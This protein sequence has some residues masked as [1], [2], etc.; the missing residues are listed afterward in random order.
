MAAPHPADRSR[1][2]GSHWPRRTRRHRDS[3]ALRN[4][5]RRRQLHP[6][7]HQVVLLRQASHRARTRTRHPPTDCRS[8]GRR[9]I[10][11]AFL[12]RRTELLYLRRPE[13]DCLMDQIHSRQLTSTLTW[14]FG[15]FVLKKEKGPARGPFSLK[16]DFP[17]WL[18]R[19]CVASRVAQADQTHQPKTQQAD[20]ARLRHARS[21]IVRNDCAFADRVSA[22]VLVADVSDA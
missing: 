8:P 16:S 21:V 9:Y 22:V 17:C 7:S 20:R 10:R 19:Y 12:H 18:G 4:A 15:A 14:R 1:S 5:L 3:Y 6:R 13:E 11:E 2:S